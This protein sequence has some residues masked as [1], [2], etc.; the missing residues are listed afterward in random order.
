MDGAGYI[1]R[2]IDENAKA[3]NDTIYFN[4][5]DAFVFMYVY[6]NAT[7]SV[8]HLIRI[9]DLSSWPSV[10]LINESISARGN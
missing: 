2:R 4:I 7:F 5:G 3:R 1:A 10:L 8:F 9:A 6:Q